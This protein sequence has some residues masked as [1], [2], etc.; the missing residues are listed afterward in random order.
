M[1]SFFFSDFF[2]AS[3]YV[4]VNDIFPIISFSK[5]V[6]RFVSTMFMKA[7]NSA[8]DNCSVED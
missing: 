5:S 4:Q 8:T 2:Q 1:F 6:L 7:Q 3:H